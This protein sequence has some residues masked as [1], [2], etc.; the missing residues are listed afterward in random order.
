MSTWSTLEEILTS[1]LSLNRRPVAVAFRDTAPAG[2]AKFSG[3]KKGVEMNSI[4]NNNSGCLDIAAEVRS[5]SDFGPIGSFDIASGHAE[6]YYLLCFD[7]GRD[8]SIPANSKLVIWQFD[9]ALDV[10]V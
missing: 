10:T 9:T 1:A 4:L 8:R 5:L 2:V 7:L 3:G 6:H